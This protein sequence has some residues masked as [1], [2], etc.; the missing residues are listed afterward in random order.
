MSKSDVCGRGCNE[1]HCWVFE[2]NV[3]ECLSSNCINKFICD[4]SDGKFVAQNLTATRPASLFGPFVDLQHRPKCITFWYMLHQG[5]SIKLKINLVTSDRSSLLK[6]EIIKNTGTVWHKMEFYTEEKIK[7]QVDLTLPGKIQK[8]TSTKM[9]TP[10]F[11]QILLTI[12]TICAFRVLNLHQLSWA[13]HAVQ[14]D[15]QKVPKQAEAKRDSVIN[16]QSYEL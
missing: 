16:P 10:L 3:A 8:V 9:Y 6:E 11:Y 13:K 12:W 14:T 7:F 2:K 1:L 15:D 5:H 4:I